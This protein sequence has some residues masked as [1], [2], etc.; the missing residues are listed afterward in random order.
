[1]TP[2]IISKVTNFCRKNALVAPKDKIVI[3]VSGGPDSL[4]LLHLLHTLS[5]QFELTLMVAH[6]NHQLRGVDSDDDADLVRQIAAHWQLPVVL[7]SYDVAALAIQRQQSL[8]EAA[9]QVRDAF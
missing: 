2:D 1:M 9:R 3:G 6:L 4:C 8:E 5:P 7:E